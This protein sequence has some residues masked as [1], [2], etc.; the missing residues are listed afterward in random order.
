MIPGPTAS[1]DIH[2]T[3]N[4]E[5]DTYGACLIVDLSQGNNYLENSSYSGYDSGDSIEEVPRTVMRQGSVENWRE[6]DINALH[7]ELE[8][9]KRFLKT[10]ADMSKIQLELKKIKSAGGHVVNLHDKVEGLEMALK[11]AARDKY[12]QEREMAELRNE[13]AELREQNDFMEVLMHPNKSI[14]K[15]VAPRKAQ[16]YGQFGAERTG[17]IKTPQLLGVKFD[18]EKSR[19][20]LGSSE[21]LPNDRLYSP[22]RSYSLSPQ[23]SPRTALRKMKEQEA[24]M[25]GLHRKI[26]SLQL[27]NKDKEVD[28]LK[29]QVTQ[30]SETI[31]KLICGI[32]NVSQNNPEISAQLLVLKKTLPNVRKNELRNTLCVPSGNGRANS[33]PLQTRNTRRVWCT[34][35]RPNDFNDGPVSF[36]L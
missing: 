12:D 7:K 25:A 36:V 28:A 23:T 3:M 22:A 33:A 21:E 15:P 19:E 34:E 17:Y 9:Q 4:E 18:D 6:Q 2:I 11:T 16:S 35:L 27:Q 14:D 26:D 5:G 10:A 13:L 1:G 24:L 8:A 30:L 32:Q 29:S 31:E 20:P